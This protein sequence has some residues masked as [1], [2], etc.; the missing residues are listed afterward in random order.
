MEIKNIDPIKLIESLQEGVVVHSKTTE[1]RYANPRALEILRLTKKQVEGKDAFDP[2][3]RFIDS[4]N[5]LL[6]HQDYPVNR[7]LTEKQPINNIEIGICD[8]STDQVTWV[9]CNAYP[10][11]D[12]NGDVEEVVVSF[13][14]IT[15]K[16]TDIPF[17]AI[18]AN[19]NDI[20]V[21]TEA[22][23]IEGNGPRIVYTNHAFSDLSGYTAE[24]AIGKTPRI[25]QGEGSSIETRN[26]IREALAKKESIQERI[27][28]YS[29]SGS[30]YWLDMNIF[31]LENAL[32]EVAYFAAVQRDISE[33]VAKES[34]LKDIAQKDPLT[35][36][37]NRRGFY[38][39]AKKRLALQ[40]ANTKASLAIIDI[41]YFK[42]S[43]IP[44]AMSV[45]TTH[46]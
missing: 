13:L 28:N 2:Q 11:L 41:D 23:P 27:L 31:P 39:A 38:S 10:Q 37:L 46:W 42:K 34:E 22:S 17:E 12:D 24:E 14:D 8:S 18:V 6:P 40:P 4:E 21:V 33:Q 25:L 45:A 35:D 5:K 9:L 16:K 30:P 26:R 7:V 32:G 3:W 19:A 15:N 43:M 20:I 36:L 1:V 29:K 44:S